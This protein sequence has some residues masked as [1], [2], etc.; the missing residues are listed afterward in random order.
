MYERR[1]CFMLCWVGWAPLTFKNV[2]AKNG[3]SQGKSRMTTGSDP[4][5]DKR[6]Y[7]LLIK[8]RTTVRRRWY[9]FLGSYP[10]ASRLNNLCYVGRLNHAKWTKLSMMLISSPWTILWLKCFF[11]LPC[12]GDSMGAATGSV[13]WSIS[14]FWFTLFYSYKAQAKLYSLSYNCSC[15]TP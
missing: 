4:K 5:C 3:W 1:F 14:S 7:V 2:G 11:E 13:C 6:S 8:V 9:V 12:F 10:P 15:K